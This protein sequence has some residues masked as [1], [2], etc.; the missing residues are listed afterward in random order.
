MTRNVITCSV[1]LLCTVHVKFKSDNQP[2]SMDIKNWLKPPQRSAPSSKKSDPADPP[3][4]ECPISPIDEHCENM[5]VIAGSSNAPPPLQQ[6]LPQPVAAAHRL[7]PSPLHHLLL[8]QRISVLR[9]QI[10]LNRTNIR[11][12]FLIVI[13]NSFIHSLCCLLYG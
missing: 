11:A 1:L 12:V 10:R 7:D 4:S 13:I 9:H 5:P 6:Q 3:P 2:G 8:H